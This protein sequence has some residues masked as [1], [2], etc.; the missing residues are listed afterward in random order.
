M[1][2]TE[3]PA[4]PRPPVP[5]YNAGVDARVKPLEWRHFN[6]E[7]DY[8]RGV[9]DANTPWNTVTICDCEQWEATGERYYVPN[10]SKTFPELADAKAAA[11]KD[12]EQRIRSAL[13]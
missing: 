6:V 3:Q 2:K 11:Q 7:H 8:G 1:T 9:W 4:A 12:Y 5:D 13:T 10:L